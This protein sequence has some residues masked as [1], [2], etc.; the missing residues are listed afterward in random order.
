MDAISNARFT[1]SSD[2]CHA[3]VA[4]SVPVIV[5]CQKV[6]NGGRP[7]VAGLVFRT[8]QQGQGHIHRGIVAMV[9]LLDGDVQRSTGVP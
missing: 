4:F 1:G 7:L 5:T 9:G 2:N 3:G 8:V 6:N